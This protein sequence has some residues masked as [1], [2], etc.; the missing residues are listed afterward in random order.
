MGEP[1]IAMGLFA[2]K[3]KPIFAASVKAVAEDGA[4]A[5]R[6]P[7][8]LLDEYRSQTVNM[9]R[10]VDGRVPTN[11]S[12]VIALF[13]AGAGVGT[14][15]VACA[16]ARGA[17]ELWKRRVLLLG[18]GS[19]RPSLPAVGEPELPSDGSPQVFE[20]PMDGLS[21]AS[22]LD[23]WQEVRQR[24]DEIVV[25]CPDPAKSSLGLQ[26]A[27]FADGVV[28][29]L[30]A[31]RTRAPVAQRLVADLRAAHANVVGAVVNRRRLHIPAAVYRLL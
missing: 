10:L 4:T 12:R 15:S 2:P 30:E 28:L 6:A 17:A 13:A 16:Y 3:E 29:V 27:S 18:A 31:E 24:H 21:P 5:R 23:F 26:I 1:P 25:D 19:G 22:T 7:W 14:T 11:G 8:W 9:L 20:L